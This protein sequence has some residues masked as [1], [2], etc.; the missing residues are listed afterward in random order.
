MEPSLKQILDAL[1]NCFN[2]FDRHLDDRDRAFADR[3]DSVD[4]RFAT[5]ETQATGIE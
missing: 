5:L 2:K 3:T 4:S 1:N